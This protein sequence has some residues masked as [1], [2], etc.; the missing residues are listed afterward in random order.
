VLILEQVAEG[1]R[2][3]PRGVQVAA[4]VQ[5]AFQVHALLLGH[6]LAGRLSA[7][8]LTLARLR[9][10]PLQHQGLAVLEVLHPDRDTLLRHGQSS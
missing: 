6:L 5:V 4:I 3:H 8:A 10:E 1:F 2:G 7:S 9:V